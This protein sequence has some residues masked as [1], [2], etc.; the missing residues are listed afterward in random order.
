MNDHQQLNIS[1]QFYCYIL[2]NNKDNRT[3]NGFTTNLDKRL[4]QHN[5]ELSGGAKS[6]AFN[7]PVGIWEIYAYVTGFPTSQSALQC[8][9][10]IKHPDNKKKRCAPYNGAIGRIKGLN[11][12]LQLEKW[13]NNSVILNKDMIL[14]VYVSDD[15]YQYIEIDKIPTN[16]TIKKIENKTTNSFQIN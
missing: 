1:K 7:G 14:T 4:R 10:R 6:T 12:V 2:K 16:I 5:R 11:I 9:W 13:T 15:Y 3:Y 8:E